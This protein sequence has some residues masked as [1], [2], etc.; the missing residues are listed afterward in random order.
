MR[1]DRVGVLI[2]MILMAVAASVEAVAPRPPEGFK[3]NPEP[4][5]SKYEKLPGVYRGNLEGIAG[6]GKPYRFK[7][8][9]ILAIEQIYRSGNGEYEAHVRYCWD[10]GGGRPAGSGGYVAHLA[11]LED[12]SIVVSWEKLAYRRYWK[13]FTFILKPDGVMKARVNAHEIFM[14]GTLRKEST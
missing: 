10:E 14:S 7:Q 2:L 8:E 3:I 9:V 4:S 13:F 5:G 1:A 6:E 12:G 11:K